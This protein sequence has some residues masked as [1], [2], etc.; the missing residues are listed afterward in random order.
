MREGYTFSPQWNYTV[1]PLN[2]AFLYIPN[3][4]F[5]AEYIQHSIDFMKSAQDC[6]DYLTYMVYA[7]QRLIAMLAKHRGIPVDTILE[8]G[9]L[10]AIQNSYTHTWG[11]KQVM[12]DNPTELERF[13]EKCR[14]R[15][16]KD[17]PEWEHIINIIETIN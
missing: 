7:E 11:A 8:W 5:K 1:R 10:H 2:T 4:E 17:F 13:C 9:D 12:R 15:I 14:N 16:K 3:E 6:N